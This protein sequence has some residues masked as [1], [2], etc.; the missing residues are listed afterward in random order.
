MR[1]FNLE[2]SRTALVE[3]IPNKYMGKKR[4]SRSEE[5]RAM[6][7]ASKYIEHLD[8]LVNDR[9]KDC[10]IEVLQDASSTWSRRVLTSRLSLRNPASLTWKKIPT[11]TS[12]GSGKAS[13][14][15]E[16]DRRL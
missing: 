16:R 12:H 6:Y 15:A 14:P 8:R 7:G 4:Q 3:L 5:T 2:R 11:L 1:E 10:Q 13:F 9:T